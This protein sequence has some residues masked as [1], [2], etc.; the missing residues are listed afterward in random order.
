MRWF[1]NHW[2]GATIGRHSLSHALRACQLPQRGS[3][4]RRSPPAP[5]LRELSSEARLREC[6]PMNVK[7]QK[8]QSQN[9]LVCKS[10]AWSNHR[11][12]L[13]QS[14]PCG[15]A[16][17]LREGAGRGGFHSTDRPENPTL[18]AI[19][20]APTKGGCHSSG[21]SLKSGVTGDFH[22]PYGRKN[23]IGV[24]NSVGAATSRPQPEGFSML[25]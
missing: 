6:T 22:R 13:P 10:L 14:R 7:T 8:F 9:G 23:R 25:G 21:Y 3:R 19:F 24:V 16:S 2:H 20:I 5:S 1:V 15:R 12:T 11:T 4:E 17:S 18:R